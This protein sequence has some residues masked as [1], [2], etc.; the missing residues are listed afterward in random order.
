VPT[1]AKLY[2]QVNG[3]D[4]I[5]Y[6]IVDIQGRLIASETNIKLPV[7]EYTTTDLKAGVYYLNVET[8]HGSVK[9][10]FVIE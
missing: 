1:S 6:N 4:I 9:R 8:I 10:E 7:L 2:A 5:A 3:L